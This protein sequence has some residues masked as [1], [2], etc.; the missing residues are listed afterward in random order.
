MVEFKAVVSDPKTGKS[1]QLNVTGH[2]AN[3]MIGKKINDE[4]DGI[5]INLPGYKLVLT[6]GS[7]K[8]GFPMRNDLTG[9][10]RK[11]TLLA[12][13]I[14]F[15]PTHEGL[16]RKKSIRGN[17]ISPDIVQINMKIKTHGPKPVEESIKAKEEKK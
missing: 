8:D 4:I 17:T 9:Q 6:G 7:D 14:G 16:R 5:F 10:R 13:G 3:S 11:R 2:Y 12:G 1:Y 15:K